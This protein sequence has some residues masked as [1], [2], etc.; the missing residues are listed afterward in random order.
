M[1]PGP[2]TIR[3]VSKSRAHL[4]LTIR[5][6]TAIT[7]VSI[8]DAGIF[9]SLFLC[10]D[11]PPLPPPQTAGGAMAASGEAHRREPAN[12]TAWRYRRRKKEHSPSALRVQIGRAHV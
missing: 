4:E 11:K 5:P 8:A 3:K 6:R 12:L 1:S 10:I 9:T 2:T 7:S